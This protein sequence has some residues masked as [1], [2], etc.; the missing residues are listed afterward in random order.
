[1]PQVVACSQANSSSVAAQ[2]QVLYAGTWSAQACVL[3]FTNLSSVFVPSSTRQQYYEQA[4]KFLL[5]EGSE[6]WSC[7]LPG[8]ICE[9]LWLWQFP[10]Q[11]S[12]QFLQKTL[13][14]L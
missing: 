6:H 5:Q 4:A 10:A 2:P 11:K 8:I 13:A 14:S 12:V 1:M 7:H 9:L 3:P